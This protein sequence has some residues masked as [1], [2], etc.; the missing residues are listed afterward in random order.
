MTTFAILNLVLFAAML[1]FLFQL[2]KTE[3]SLSRRVLLGLIGGTLFGFYL[4]F[5]FG[6]THEV[7]NQRWSGLAS[8]PTPM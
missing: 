3:T 6:F 5:A 8:S 2:A 1:G 7:T 4:Q